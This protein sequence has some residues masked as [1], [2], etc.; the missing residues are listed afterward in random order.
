MRN[1][2]M[3]D[4]KLAVLAYV[5]AHEPVRRDELAAHLG[6]AEDTVSGHLRKLVD[7]GRL[8]KRRVNRHRCMWELAKPPSIAKGFKPLRHALRDREQVSSV[9]DYARR[10]AA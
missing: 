7:L 9:W 2:R 4:Q 5:Q 3:S 8:Q 10:C 6:I 1:R